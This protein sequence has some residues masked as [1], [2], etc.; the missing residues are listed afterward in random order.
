M[1]NYKIYIGI[2]S[3]DKKRVRGSTSIDFRY[4]A[5]AKMLHLYLRGK[6][7]WCT[8]DVEPGDAFILLN[9]GDALKIQG[10]KLPM[11]PNDFLMYLLGYPD[12]TRCHREDYYEKNLKAGR[13]KHLRP[14]FEEEVIEGEHYRMHL[15]VDPEGKIYHIVAYCCAE[16]T[17][18]EIV[19]VFTRWEYPLRFPKSFMRASM[20]RRLGL[21]DE[22]I[23]EIRSSWD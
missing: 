22:Q 3:T 6:E 5:E 14:G 18:E 17:P 1:A 11:H 7:V 16:L 21:T 4:D 15:A 10:M 20:R 2:Q 12:G 9:T 13:K 23:A 19:E 8:D